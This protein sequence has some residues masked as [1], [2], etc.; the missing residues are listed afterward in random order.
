MA[1]SRNGNGTA[2]AQW[3]PTLVSALVVVTVLIGGFWSVADP[4]GNLER[5]EAKFANYLT[6]REHEEFRNTLNSRIERMNRDIHEIDKEQKHRTGALERLNSFE[7]RLDALRQDHNDL[8]RSVNSAVTLNDQI[9]T[10]QNDIVRLRERLILSPK[11]LVRTPS[12]L[13]QKE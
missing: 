9:K 6:I 7:K 3:I 2:I 11:D 5:I 10:M 13:Q 4:R 12:G 1:S 8:H